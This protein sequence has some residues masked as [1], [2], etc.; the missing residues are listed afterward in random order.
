[1]TGY[2]IAT[3][4]CI[5]CG[6]AFA[7]NPNLVP[8]SSAITGHREPICLRCVERINPV[9]KENGLAPIVVLPGAYDVAEEGEL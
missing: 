1:M 8:S 9:R 7:F 3:G 2:F 5:G 4:A 6:R